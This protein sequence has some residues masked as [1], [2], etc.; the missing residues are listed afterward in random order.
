MKNILTATGLILTMVVIMLSCKHEIP[1][2]NTGGNNGGGNNGGGN[3][4][5]TQPC[6]TDTV[7][8]VNQVLPLL[9][10][11]CSM[12]GCH[13][14]ASHQD[15]VILTNYTSIMSTGDVQPGNPSGSDIYKAIIKTDPGDRMPPP[16]APAFTQ[17]QKD[18]IYKWI[19]QGAK[20]NACNGCD[21][22]VF[23]YSGAIGPLINNYCKGCHSGTAPSGN[24]SL[25]NYNE[26]KAIA[27]NG[28]FYG[29]ITHA[30]GFSAMPK[31]ANKWSDC[32]IKQV[33]K[34]IAAGSPNN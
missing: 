10:S 30:S 14:A 26:V 18:I 7:Y 3:T 29:S 23:T 12:T 8:F 28:S 1:F 2:G 17:A 21:T 25:T 32:Q 16:P 31:N 9:T 19:L 24:I 6:S 4:G 34:W 27:V 22:T 5:G 13:D 11:N 33:Q 15:G 20:N